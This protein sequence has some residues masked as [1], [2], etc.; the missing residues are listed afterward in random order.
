MVR[1]R[2]GRLSEF[3]LDVAAAFAVLA[4][5]L[6]LAQFLH[7][8]FGVT[9]LAVV[10]LAGVTIAATIRG[11]RAAIAAAL[12]GMLF[13][14][15]FLDLR[16]PETTG[17][18]EDVLN[19]SVFLVVALIT[20]ALAGRLHDQAADS[21][22]RAERMEALFRASRTI[23]DE[24]EP[25]LWKILADTLSSASG[26][27]AF[28][29]DGNG[30]LQAQSGGSGPDAVAA[31][32]LARKLLSSSAT[33]DRDS[34]WRAR[35]IS[36]PTAQ[37]GVL[38]WEAE[39]WDDEIEGTVALLGELASASLVRSQ[40]RHEQIRLKAEEEANRLREALLS[41]ISHDFRSPL[42]AIIGSSTSLLEYGEKFDPVV[43][44]DLLLNIQVE[45]EKLNQFVVNLLNMTRLQSGVI[46]P[47]IQAIAAGEVISKAV[48]RLERHSNQVVP[49]T[50]LGDCTIQ[51]DPL[52]LEQAL[53]NVL[54]NAVKYGGGAEGLGVRCDANGTHCEIV[55]ADC[56]PGLPSEDQDGMFTKFHFAK[57]GTRPTGTGLGLSISRG[58]VEAMGGTIRARNRSDGR[59]GLEI[60]ITLPGTC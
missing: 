31:V 52:L 58:F 38:V 46:T 34:K 45:G 43:T 47:A 6:L 59:P 13:Y 51:A 2:T 49:V 30:T 48:E 29:I 14:R 42:A 41:S 10:F 4:T 16:T 24:D 15:L 11:A 56:G 32:E 3:I 23:S 19:V 36:A 21:R 17:V 25:A 26:G 8:A 35:V 27:V 60:A 40:A 57:A 39:P 37:L 54:D 9:R 20:G 1:A 28:A 55:V 44:R 12:L 7:S 53:Y 5:A 18:A 22:L 33:V 50:V